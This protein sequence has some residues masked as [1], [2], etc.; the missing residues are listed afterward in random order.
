MPKLLRRWWMER[1]C[2][3]YRI[4]KQRWVF[5]HQHMAAYL[6]CQC[7]ML[8][9]SFAQH[10]SDLHVRVTLAAGCWWRQPLVL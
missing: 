9:G 10:C 4:G 2:A 7:A 6:K 1:C 5:E 3:G 8:C